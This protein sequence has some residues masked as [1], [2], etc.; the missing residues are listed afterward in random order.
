MIYKTTSDNR[1]RQLIYEKK[2]KIASINA[3][4]NILLISPTVTNLLIR[5]SATLD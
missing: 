2:H 4:K 1:E 5:D 3:N